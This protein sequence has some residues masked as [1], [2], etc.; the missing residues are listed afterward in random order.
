MT[1]NSIDPTGIGSRRPARA[2]TEKENPAALAR[3]PDRNV[4][5]FSAPV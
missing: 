5:A 2:I 1:P 4:G 3:Q